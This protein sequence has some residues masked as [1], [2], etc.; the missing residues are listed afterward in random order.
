MKYESIYVNVLKYC[1]S[2]FPHRAPRARI[3]P[4]SP[5]RTRPVASSSTRS[6]WPCATLPRNPNRSPA[7]PPSSPSCASTA[8]PA[9]PASSQRPASRRP[10]WTSQPSRPL[11]FV[12]RR[13][14]R[15]ATGRRRKCG[16]CKVRVQYTFFTYSSFVRIV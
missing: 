8:A 15:R 4:G 13:G 6:T 9:P 10:T 12:L 2:F 7:A 14:T 1:N 5:H 11:Y 3:Y 16:G